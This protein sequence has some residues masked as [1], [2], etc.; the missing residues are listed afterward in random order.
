MNTAAG[1]FYR[2][3]TMVHE[4]RRHTAAPKARRAEFGA[5]DGHKGLR[6]GAQ[7]TMA[8]TAMAVFELNSRGGGEYRLAGELTFATA[9]EALRITAPLFSDGAALRFDLADIRRA[10][11]AGVAL[12]VE[13]VRRAGQSGSTMRYAHFPEPLSAIIRVSGVE[14]LLPLDSTPN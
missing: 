3:L 14:D 10:D 13:W 4:R 5:A 7:R 8:D 11:S 1:N 2:T 9:S 12:L 6:E